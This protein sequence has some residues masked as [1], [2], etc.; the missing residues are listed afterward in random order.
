LG[1]KNKSDI[2]RCTGEVT[3]LAKIETYRDLEIWQK[4]IDVVKEIYTLTAKFPKEES[5]GLTSQMK[6][7]AI[8]IPSNAAEGFRRQYNKEFKQFL[9]IVLGSCAE[10]ETQITI[11][12]ELGY[13][14]SQKEKDLIENLDHI[15]RMTSNLIKKL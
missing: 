7:A 4:G 2:D 3:E 13:I 15:C 9:Y 11:S 8:S 5:Y 14:E 6:R 10:L 12:R 1:R